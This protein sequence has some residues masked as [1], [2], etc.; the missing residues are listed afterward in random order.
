MTE[1]S[2]WAIEWYREGD[3]DPPLRAFLDD[4]TGRNRKEAIA[5]MEMLQKWGDQLRAPRS[6]PLGKGL[7][8][9]RGH[10]VRIF[11]IFRRG[12]R[13]VLLDGI[14]KKQDRIPQAALDRIRHYQ[15]KIKAMDAKEERGP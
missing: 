8:E 7:F 12:R 2:E 1:P 10:Q 5:L 6:G 4:L 3:G 9:L 15:Q 11:Y 13:V 14:I